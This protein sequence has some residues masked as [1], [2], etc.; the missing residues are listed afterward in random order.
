[1]EQPH[2]HPRD[3]IP[4][5]LR[6]D[7]IRSGLN[8]IGQALSIFDADLR[9]AVANDQYQAM[10]DLPHRLTRPGTSFEDTIRFL[11]ARGEYGPQDDPDAAVAFRVEQARTFQPHYFERMRVNGRWIAVEGAPLSQGGWITVYTD[12]TDI[13][14]RDRCCGRG[15]RNYPNRCWTMPNACRPPTAN[16][17][18]PTPPCKRR[19]AS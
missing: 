16:W 19:S 7:L 4:D 15:R 2:D 6:A 10:F 14:R 13:K 8:L 11:V 17:P 12:I 9:L 5:R 18:P 3:V 1:M